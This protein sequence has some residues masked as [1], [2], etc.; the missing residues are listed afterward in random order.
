MIL[1]AYLT[2]ESEVCLKDWSLNDNYESTV[3]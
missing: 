1:D 3:S 2:L